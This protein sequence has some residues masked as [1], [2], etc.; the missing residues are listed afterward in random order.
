MDVR[1]LLVGLLALVCAGCSSNMVHSDGPLFTDVGQ[2]QM[3]KPGIWMGAAE[4]KCAFNVKQP[5]TKWPRCAPYFFVVPGDP[6]AHSGDETEHVLVI[7]G[8]RGGGPGVVQYTDDESDFFYLAYS[9][10][11]LD[12][13]G[14]GVE[15]LLWLV[16]CGPPHKHKP[17]TT[18]EREAADGG[19]V[20]EHR[21]T[22]RPFVPDM[23]TLHPLPGLQM[24]NGG[25]S[26]Q[27]PEAVRNAAVRSLAWAGARMR[28]VWLRDIRQDDSNQGPRFRPGLVQKA[29]EE[30]TA[31]T[32]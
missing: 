31:A 30:T 12:N 8:A 1:P 16:Q 19:L 18:I 20:V 22:D 29:A 2:S 9:L 10:N 11:R 4:R 13:R 28:F 14:R 23:S 7:G 26:A 3:L 32:P 25:C 17:I 15:G 24:R 27:N 21:I 6:F 5:T